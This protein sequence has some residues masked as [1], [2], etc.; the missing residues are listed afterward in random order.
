MKFRTAIEPIKGRKPI[1][2]D[3]SIIMLGSCFTSEVG[4][5]LYRDGFN[6]DINPMGALYNPVTI[7]NA[8]ERAMESRFYTPDEFVW[9]DGTWHCL[10][11]PTTYQS[12]GAEVLASNVNSA[13]TAMGQRLSNADIWIVT[14]GTARIYTFEDNRIV[15]NCHKLPGNRFTTRLLS[16]DEIISRWEPLINNRRVIFT[17]SPIRHLADGLHGNQLSKATLQLAVNHMNKAEYFPAYEILIDD[18][19]DYRFY[20][21]DMKHPSETAVDYIYEQFADTYFQPPT[22]DLAIKR[23]KDALAMAHHTIISK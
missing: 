18:L 12:E 22:V 16:I 6:I 13:L 17:I 5:R 1:N 10:D 20:A 21:S 15:G 7:A 2:H 11:F 23:R 8:I 14:F 19:R 4:K 9:H 3:M